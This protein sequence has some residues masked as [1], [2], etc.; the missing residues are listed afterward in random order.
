MF[1]AAGAAGNPW[2]QPVARERNLL[3]T[4]TRLIASLVCAGTALSLS[5]T[6]HADTFKVTTKKDELD[7]ECKKRDCSIREALEAAGPSIDRDTIKIPRGKYVLELGQLDVDSGVKIRGAGARKTRI[8]ADEASRVMEVTAGP[9]SI[10]KLTL[11]GGNA[12][13][14]DGGNFPGDAGAVLTTTPAPLTLSQV[15]IVGNAAQMGGGAVSAP[16]ESGA[17][18]ERQAQALPDR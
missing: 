2:V 4:R 5:A 8:D 11:T 14:T 6:A 18:T 17:A 12:L 1:S 3:K 16:V 9:T 15:A 7:A 10:S 13:L